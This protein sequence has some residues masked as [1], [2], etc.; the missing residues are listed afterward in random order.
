VALLAKVV[1]GLA[2][3]VQGLVTF[4]HLTVRGTD[5]AAGSNV[6][7]YVHLLV[8]FAL[9]ALL[10]RLRRGKR[11]P[12]EVAFHDLAC[13]LIPTTFAFAAL[14]AAPASLRPQ[15]PLVV[16]TA[17]LLI[18]RGVLVPSTGRRTALLGLGVSIATA[19]WTLLHEWSDAAELSRQ[20]VVVAVLTFTW[21]VMGGVVI[22][23]VASHTIFGLRQKVR[24][25]MQIGQYTLLRKIGEG[26]MGVVWEARHAFLR[27]RTAV[28]L[29]PAERA[30]EEA[31]QRFE[32][33]V[34]LTSELTHP[35]TIA[36]YDYGRS[37]EGIFYYAM[38]L[39]DGIDLQALVDRDGPQPPGLVAHVLAQ[40]CGALAEAHGVGLIHRDVKPANLFL[41]ER[42]GT[43][44]V[45][46]VLD[47]GLVKREMGQARADLSTT[48]VVRGT[49]SYMA[50]EAMT[51]PDAV[52]ART[53][54]Y[55]IGAVG[56]FLLAGRPVFEGATVLE[57]LARH[58]H[59]KPV[60]P[61]EL[62][63]SGA[64]AE[65]EALVLRCLEKDPSARPASAAEL[66]ESFAKASARCEWT[67]VAARGSW[68]RYLSLNPPSEGAMPAPTQLT[69]EV[70]ERR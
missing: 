19:L 51:N 12:A 26:G 7:V 41:C 10:L 38:E 14:W 13:V 30:G 11:S 67:P 22:A 39:L 28:K 43:P 55:A 9:F 45:A 44:F 4:V 47:F 52:D 64:P 48:N 24:E 5:L 53:D 57:V 46:K 17:Y 68:P 58:L 29:L 15:L 56:Y 16:N 6:T 49:P 37:A 32:R 63:K 36:I 33:E 70:R 18:L 25:A 61:S 2:V 23:T 62:V 8:V 60:A 40:A 42:G 35:N 34:Q 50:P 59:E 69:V 54:L 3:A 66:A 1:L 20:G 31:I 65:L 21:S 27:R